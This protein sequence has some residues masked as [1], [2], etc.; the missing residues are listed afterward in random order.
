VI[1]LTNPPEAAAEG[2]ARHSGECHSPLFI[3]GQFIHMIR[4]PRDTFIS[5]TQRTIV[6][7]TGWVKFTAKMTAREWVACIESFASEAMA[8]LGYHRE[9]V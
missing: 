7:R 6:D 1:D 4:V 8:L 5:V 2:D 9:V 3:G